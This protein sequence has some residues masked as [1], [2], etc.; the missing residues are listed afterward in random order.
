MTHEPENFLTVAWE[1]ANAAGEIIRANWHKPITIEHKGA[2]DLVTSV[3]REAEQKIIEIISG[4]FANHSI[5]AEEKTSI[6]TN[7][8]EYRWIVDPLDGTTNFAHGYP[9]VSIS[10]AL[11]QNGRVI[12]GLVYDPLR[13]ECFTAIRGHG[14]SLDGTPIYTSQIKELDKALLATGFPYDRREHADFY[15]DFFKAFLT[16]SQGIRRGGSAALDLCYLACGR[17]DGFWELKL[18]PWDIAAGSLI[19]AEAGGKLSDFCAGAFSIRG[20]ETLA[21]NGLIHTEMS[22]ITSEIVKRHAID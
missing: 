19:V 13:R 17:L 9:Q 22:Q 7:Q 8:S 21:S 16:R 18:K 10:I 14:A 4:S 5:I 2:I 3:D 11:E 12:I 6:E 20:N 1:A 15:L